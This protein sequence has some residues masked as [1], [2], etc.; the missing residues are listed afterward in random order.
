MEQKAA[1]M[2]YEVQDRVKESIIAFEMKPLAYAHNALEPSISERTMQLHHGKHYATYVENLNKLIV[3]T[4]FEGMDDL[5]KVV[6][7]ANGPIFNNAAQA[8]N[9]EFYFAQFAPEGDGVERE[10]SGDLLA[11]IERDF[12]SFDEMKMTMASSASRLFGSGWVWLV[13]DSNGTLSVENRTN[14][15]N[16]MTDGMM[17]VLTL[18]VWEHAYYVDYHNRRLDS[19][20]HIWDVINWATIAER[21]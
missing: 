16:P 3:G 6:M 1:T 19:I 5:K 17:P 21:Y 4:E 10:P 13:K 11:A 14:A 12:G 20:N 7:R 18:D 8:W 9:H 2:E 15:G